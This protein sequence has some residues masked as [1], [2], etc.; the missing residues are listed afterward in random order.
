[1]SWILLNEE[2]TSQSESI[3]EPKTKSLNSLLCEQQKAYNLLGR[4]GLVWEQNLAQLLQIKTSQIF[5][6]R[7]LGRVRN[8]I[9]GLMKKY[10]K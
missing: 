5:K 1:M 10:K 2:I 3:S 4:L 8:G 9:L 6:R 7:H